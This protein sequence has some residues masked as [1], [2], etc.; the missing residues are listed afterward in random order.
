MA[1]LKLSEPIIDALVARLEDDLPAPIAELNAEPGAE[2]QI[3][4]PLAILPY[5]PSVG[6]LRSWPTIGIQELP[7]RFQDDIGSSVVAVCELVVIVFESDSDLASL[8]ARLRRQVQ[9]V[10]TVALEGR[11]LGIGGT[12]A[13]SVS[14]VSTTPGPTLGDSEDPEQVRTWTSWA[15]VALRFLREE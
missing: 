11:E 7:T 5:V 1:V 15:G 3:A 4:Q 14:L 10:T 2:V 13:Y 8:T 12:D 9:A 6:L